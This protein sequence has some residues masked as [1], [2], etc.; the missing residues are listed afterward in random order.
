MSSPAKIRA[1]RRNALKSTGPRTRAGKAVVA[2]NALQHGLNLAAFCDPALAREV[3]DLAREIE[4]SV[5]GAEADAIGHELAC[6]IAEAIID[7]RRVRLAKL[8]LVTRLHADPGD[9]RALTQLWRLDRY[10]G[11]AFSRRKRAI[12]EFDAVVIPLRLAKQSQR[13]KAN[14]FRRGAASSS[15]STSS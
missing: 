12:R 10:E 8:P 1:N 9:R 6:R 4:T 5:T 13:T 2:C 14:D 15:C 3:V 11:R 7:M